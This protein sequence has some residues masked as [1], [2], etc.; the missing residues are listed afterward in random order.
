MVN[1]NAA[2]WG[3]TVENGGS[4]ATLLAAAMPAVAN[5][6]CADA[7]SSYP[8]IGVVFPSN[9]CAGYQGGGVDTCQGDSGGPLTFLF[10]HPQLAGVTSWGL[11]CARPG[12]PGVYA[13][14]SS[15]IEWI[16]QHVTTARTFSPT[17]VIVT[18][19]S[20]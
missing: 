2:G 14:V 12:L 10:G 8:S 18:V 1:T 20:N 17:A 15:Y 16:T 7:Y 13:R 4:T 5:A 11:G 3:A 6:S 9:L 19:T